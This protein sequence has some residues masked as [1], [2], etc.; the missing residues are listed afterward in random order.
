M[1]K[2]EKINTSD[3]LKRLGLDEESIKSAQETLKRASDLWTTKENIGSQLE[4]LKYSAKRAWESLATISSLAAMLLIIATFNPSLI[5]INNSV[6]ILLTV[7]LLII[8]IVVWL[9]FFD[10]TKAMDSSLDEMI[11]TIEKSNITDKENFKALI[12]KGRKPALKGIL[13]FIIHCIFT[14]A[15]LLIILLIWKIDLIGLLIKT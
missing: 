13:P 9:N 4:L 11:K 15:V 8:S 10:T 5:S 14:L 1:G 12:A 3:F 7:L 2:E 6:R